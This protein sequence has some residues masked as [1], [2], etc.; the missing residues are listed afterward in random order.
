MCFPENRKDI[1]TSAETSLSSLYHTWSILTRKTVPGTASEM[2]VQNHRK[3]NESDGKCTGDPNHVSL[4]FAESADRTK[5]CIFTFLRKYNDCKSNTYQYEQNCKQNSHCF[6]PPASYFAILTHPYIHFKRFFR[7]VLRFFQMVLQA[8][9]MILRLSR[10][11][12]AAQ[13]ERASCH[14]L[15][16]LSI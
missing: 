3:Q 4:A 9:L 14:I 2:H 6:A 1:S 7:M 5:S 15:E 11:Q 10:L 12:T 16:V 8:F 13:K